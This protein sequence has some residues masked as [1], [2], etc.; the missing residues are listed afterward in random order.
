MQHVLFF[1]NLKPMKSF[2]N[3]H[4]VFQDLNS[5]MI[6]RSLGKRHSVSAQ[7]AHTLS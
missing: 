5:T 3:A 4:R 6:A 7:S 1:P 2:R